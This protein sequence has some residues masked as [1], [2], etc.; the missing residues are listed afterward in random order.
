M[1]TYVISR[2][3]SQLAQA[4]GQLS[5]LENHFQALVD[6]FKHANTRPNTAASQ[7]SQVSQTGSSAAP[8]GQKKHKK[9][10]FELT[11]VSG[12]SVGVTGGYA[13]EHRAHPSAVRM[14]QVIHISVMY[15]YT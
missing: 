15:I 12:V 7:R 6:H 4:R 3:V 11:G 10:M 2:V 13:W 9:Q 1:Y 8:A 14:K 5:A